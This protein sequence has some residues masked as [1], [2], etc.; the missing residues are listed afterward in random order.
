[1][2]HYA[3]GVFNILRPRQNGLNFADVILKYIL[4]NENIW[5][6]INMSLEFVSKG[7]IN[8]IPAFVQIWTNDG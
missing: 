4:F 2:E 3:G 7:R 1:M 5:M 6:S 8:N